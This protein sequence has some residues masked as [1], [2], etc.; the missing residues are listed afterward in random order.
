MLCLSGKPDSFQKDQG[1]ENSLSLFIGGIDRFEIP[2]LMRIP[3]P[4]ISTATRIFKP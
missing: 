1:R 2:D 4:A 3:G